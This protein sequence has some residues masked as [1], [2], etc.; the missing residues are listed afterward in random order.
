MVKHKIVMQ[1][2]DNAP[3]VQKGLLKQLNNLKDGYGDDVSI[4]VVCHGP[5]LDLLHKER[6]EYEAQLN[7]L[8][9]RGIVFLAC[10]NT[11]KG[12]N[13]PKEAIMDGFDF[14]PMGIGHIVERQEVGWSYIKAGL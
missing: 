8:K 3:N 11:L 4:E 9:S 6:S 10:E 5:G 1:L 14:V 2:V 7:A 13:I 12:R